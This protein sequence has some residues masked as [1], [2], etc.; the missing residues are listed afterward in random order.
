M[1]LQRCGYALVLMLS[2]CRST[3]APPVPIVASVVITPENTQFRSAGDTATLRAIVRNEA[4]EEI[5]VPVTWGTSAPLSVS[6]TKAGRVRSLG[7]GGAGV[8]ATAGGVTGEA[9]AWIPPQP[10]YPERETFAPALGV[11]VA[12]MTR[13]SDALYVQELIVG[14]GVIVTKGRQVS[15]KSKVW[16]PDGTPIAGGGVT[17]FGA[18]SDGV[19]DVLGQSVLGMRVGGTRRIV[20][21]S[22][23]SRGYTL[24]SSRCGSTIVAEIE[25]IP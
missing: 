12:S 15:A 20:A 8:T 7:C 5:R 2:G 17:T 25:L 10:T 19:V 18:G 24:G 6:I 21:A 23:L 22:P 11:N 16:M 1:R 3:S 9:S 4:G 13:M 14:G